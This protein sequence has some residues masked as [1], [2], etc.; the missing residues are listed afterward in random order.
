MSVP[1]NNPR[2]LFEELHE[3]TVAALDDTAT[4]AKMARLDQL[5]REDPQARRLYVR[6]VDVSCNLRQW[7]SRPL[8]ESSE[9]GPPPEEVTTPR[10]LL[11]FL[12]D[13]GQR[14]WGF[15]SDHSF[16]VSALAVLVLVG[17][18]TAT[19][20]YHAA[21][22]R[23]GAGIASGNSAKGP[24]NDAVVPRSGRPDADPAALHF[25]VENVAVARLAQVTGCRWNGAAPAP[26]PGEGLTAGRSLNLVSGVAEID[27]DIG[28]KVIL[29]SPAAFQVESASSAR[30]EMG[31]VTVE[32]NRDAARGFKIYTPRATFVDQGTEF[33]VE[34]TPGGGSK[35]HVF[36]GK[37]EVDLKAREVGPQ[38]LF[39][40]HG[41]RLE[42]GD[43]GMMLVADTGECF[44]RS[45]AQAQRDRHVVAY[46]RFEDHPVGIVVPDTRANGAAVRGTVDSSFNGNDLF[47][48]TDRTRPTFSADVPAAVVPQSGAA[49]CGC[50]DNTEPPA[51]GAPTRDVYTRSSFSHAAPIDI[52]KITPAQW[53]IEASVKPGRLQQGIQTFVGR[54]GAA[55][56]EAV[57]VASRLAFQITSQDRFSIRFADV[58]N[59][60]HEA[61]AGQLAVQPNHWYHLAAVSDGHTLR[62][63]VDALD[64]RG[65]RLQA[66][67]RLPETG[68]TALGNCSDEAEWSIGR[69]RVAGKPAEWFQGWI[70]EVRVSDVALDPADFLFANK[71][72]SPSPIANGSNP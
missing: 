34:V 42:A 47:T 59:R 68:S 70:D 52:Q 31:K 66:T 12:G 56:G 63:Y 49:N 6:Y 13:L 4:P 21:R 14:G 38:C 27:F 30:L 17:T 18:L 43:H 69:G 58:E 25:P 36:K 46:W 67:V 19:A 54:D 44:I 7:A 28:A 57:S 71:T 41:A 40:N 23:G 60:F 72:G 39:A 2:N 37:V 1:Q 29:Q 45:I 48:H 55:P 50:L 24:E 64:G 32:I 53:T 8:P 16:L 51:G 22:G 33:G 15:L 5:L 9:S 10:G 11:G 65:Y 26:E 61:V 20:V 35:V 62:L 3:L